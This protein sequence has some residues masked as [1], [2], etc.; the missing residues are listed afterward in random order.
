LKLEPK[1]NIRDKIKL[2]KNNLSKLPKIN[3]LNYEVLFSHI[4]SFNKDWNITK[5]G[6][7]VGGSEILTI[8]RNNAF[9][10]FTGERISNI[11]KDFSFIMERLTLVNNALLNK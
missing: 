5:H 2:L 7:V 1:L 10:Q 6:I 9:H 8:N 4:I 11:S 3:D